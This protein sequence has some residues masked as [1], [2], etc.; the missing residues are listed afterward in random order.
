[1]RRFL[2]FMVTVLLC[3]VISAQDNATTLAKRYPQL[4]G[5]YKEKLL[6]ARAHFI[7]AIDVSTS[8]NTDG[9]F[10][11]VVKGLM[12]F[13]NAVPDSSTITVIT[14]GKY[15]NTVVL[16]Q[17]VTQDSRS[18]LI[19]QLSNLKATESNTDLQGVV[20]ALLDQCRTPRDVT[21][22]F[23][24]S[25][26][27]NDPPRARYT[28]K[29]WD[30][31]AKQSAIYTNDHIIDVF[32]LQLPISSDAGRDLD[33]VKTV[34]P[35]MNTTN[36]SKSNLEAWFSEQ[37]SKIEERNLMIMVESDLNRIV[38]SKQ[39]NYLLKLRIDRT[40]LLNINGLGDLPAYIDGV[41]IVASESKQLQGIDA[42]HFKSAGFTN[43]SNSK[44]IGI[45]TYKSGLPWNIKNN[46]VLALKGQYTSPAADEIIRL[47]LAEEM[48]AVNPIVVSSR[49]FVITWNFWWTMAGF[50]LV[51]FLIYMILATLLTKHKLDGYAVRINNSDPII[52]KGK[53][54]YILSTAKGDFLLAM[55]GA[56][57]LKIAMTLS[58]PFNLIIR[59]KIALSITKGKP[60]VSFDSIPQKKRNC[61]TTPLFK[62]IIV[63]QDLVSVSLEFIRIK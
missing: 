13:I 41:K 37:I 10:D 23:M 15:I 52:L 29:E 44:R 4:Y 28:A 21:E 25:D 43:E 63:A 16:N 18:E 46:L 58:D 12:D 14:F 59:R 32:A 56:L 39:L 49:K 30:D 27:N 8:M 61:Y 6:S 60:Q 5:H 47:G 31:L 1:M 50:A 51:L 17:I 36:F 19:R 7:T 62:K 20:K 55:P 22:V 40:V 38:R 2:I 9:Y 34:F 54:R 57:E 3:S 11:R 33:K 48:N 45:V 53:R 24:F 35:S 26:F 42:F